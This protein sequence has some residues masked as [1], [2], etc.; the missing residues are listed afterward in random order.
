MNKQTNEYVSLPNICYPEWTQFD[1]DCINYVF[2]GDETIC[3]IM[4]FLTLQKPILVK[5]Y[6]YY[7]AIDP[8]QICIYQNNSTVDNNKKTTPEP[9][10]FY[11]YLLEMVYS[12]YFVNKNSL[13]GFLQF[14]NCRHSFKMNHFTM[15]LRKFTQSAN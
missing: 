6:H 2:H 8:R 12:I 14:C 7:F 9:F 3:Q 11:F 15:G 13:E 10:N 5:D 1:I 4:L